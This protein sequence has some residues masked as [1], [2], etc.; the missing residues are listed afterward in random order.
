MLSRSP[1]R[2]IIQMYDIGPIGEKNGSGL[3]GFRR[4]V[5]DPGNKD[6]DG[7]E[8]ENPENSRVEIAIFLIA[9]LHILSSR[10]A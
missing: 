1:T 2:H 6:G 4:L 7:Q 3:C 5:R 9:A 8:I 10:I